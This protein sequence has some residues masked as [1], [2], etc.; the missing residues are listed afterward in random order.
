MLPEGRKPEGCSICACDRAV[1][2]LRS[3]SLLLLHLWVHV[4][5]HGKHVF[6]SA[7]HPSDDMACSRVWK[8]HCLSEGIIWCIW[9]ASKIANWSS[10]GFRTFAWSLASGSVAIGS[11]VP[12]SSGWREATLWHTSVSRVTVKPQSPLC[13]SIG[14]HLTYNRRSAWLTSYWLPTF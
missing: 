13:L 3:D 1:A 5:G 4:V 12:V 10:Y 8:S 7:I 6:P 14:N 2:V 9:S 11:S